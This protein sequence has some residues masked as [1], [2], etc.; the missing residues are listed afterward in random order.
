M[1]ERMCAG[2]SPEICGATRMKYWVYQ[3]SAP[4]L[5]MVLKS[6]D[7]SSSEDY[8]KQ[9]EAIYVAA[10][11]EYLVEVGTPLPEVFDPKQGLPEGYKVMAYQGTVWHQL[12][13]ADILHLLYDWDGGTAA[14][15]VGS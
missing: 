15:L 13:D 3:P 7:V 4:N 2:M 6:L 8:T 5:P 1:S 14:R 11:G 10:H 9:F 12:C